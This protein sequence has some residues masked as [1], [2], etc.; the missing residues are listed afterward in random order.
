[1]NLARKKIW[2]AWIP[3]LVWLGLIALES[4]NWLSASNT[5]HFLFPIFHFFTGVSPKQFEVWNEYFRKVGHF[6]G[7]FTLSWLL[8]GAWRVTLPQKGDPHW[9]WHWARVAFFMSALVASLDEWHQT[10]LPAR[11]GRVEDVMLDT[12]A[13]ITA[14]L[15]IWLILQTRNLRRV[16]VAARYDQAR[17]PK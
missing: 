5:S 14:Q 9:S 8:F 7:Y 17:E 16:T 11:T 12:S 15:V 13:V 2:K 3:S 10:Y 6:V 4:T 1:L